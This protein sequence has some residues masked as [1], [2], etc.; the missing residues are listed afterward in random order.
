MW[1]SE[2]KAE[3]TLSLECPHPNQVISSIKFPSFGTPHGTCG[4][5]SHCRCRSKDVLSVLKKVR[6]F[7]KRVTGRSS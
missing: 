7:I 2:K 3:A 1:A 6:S 5:F 4:S